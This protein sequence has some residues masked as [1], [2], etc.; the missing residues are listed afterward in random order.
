[1]EPSNPTCDHRGLLP[2][3]RPRCRR[4]RP[5]PRPLA[6]PRRPGSHQAQ[7]G[8]VGLTRALAAVS[9]PE[10]R[11]NTLLSLLLEGCFTTGP[12][13]GTSCRSLAD[14]PRIVCVQ[15]RTPAGDR[16]SLSV[17]SGSARTA[18]GSPCARSLSKH[19]RYRT[20][21]SHPRTHRLVRLIIESLSPHD[22][23]QVTS[24]CRQQV[25]LSPCLP[26]SLVARDETPKPGGHH[27][28]RGSTAR[29]PGSYRKS[30]HSLHPE[31]QDVEAWRARLPLLGGSICR[32]HNTIA[33]QC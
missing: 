20:L 26:G 24:T 3:R 2:D 6:C 25:L 31:I 10:M 19:W 7:P 5:A 1:M 23:R 11:A 13:R 12:T 22:R 32:G 14:H 9:R 18:R 8:I 15:L 30:W 4:A 27:L 17:V 21:A 29:Q 28:S 33:R 16:L